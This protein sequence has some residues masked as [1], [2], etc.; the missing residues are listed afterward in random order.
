MPYTSWSRIQRSIIVERW[1]AKS[2]SRI[3]VVQ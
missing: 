3:N 2:I 1:A